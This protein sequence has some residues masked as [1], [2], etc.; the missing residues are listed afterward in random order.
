DLLG[1]LIR[2]SS[3]R[4]GVL[5]ERTKVEVRLAIAEQNDEIAPAFGQKGEGIACWSE[6]SGYRGLIE[7]IRIGV[8]PQEVFGILKQSGDRRGTVGACGQENVLDALIAKVQLGR[9][10]LRCAKGYHASFPRWCGG[11]TGPH[12]L[13]LIGGTLRGP[14]DYW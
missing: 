5:T 1:R 6:I 7:R 12:F 11:V 4:F 8:M 14:S 2:A 13:R 9:G 3:A 10:G